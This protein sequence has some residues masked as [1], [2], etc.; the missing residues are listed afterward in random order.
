[1]ICNVD[2]YYQV[3]GISEC[4]YNDSEKK[5]KQNHSIQFD[6]WINTWQ[7][8][9]V[10]LEM[11]LWTVN[12]YVLKWT[13]KKY[14]N[15]SKTWFYLDELNDN[16]AT[17]SHNILFKYSKWIFLCANFPFEWADLPVK[18][19]K[20]TL[21]TSFVHVIWNVNELSNMFF[22]FHSI[23]FWTSP[24]LTSCSIENLP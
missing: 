2:A 9:A 5:W 7:F 24:D 11:R 12:E 14:N 10:C 15:F 22:F 4:K 16:F 23:Q 18:R 8:E 1:M 21:E 3:S 17:F 6:N 13:V 19:T 20:L